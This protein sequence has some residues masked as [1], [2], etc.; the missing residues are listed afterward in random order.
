M[1]LTKHTSPLTGTSKIRL[2]K[3]FASKQLIHKYKEAY[4]INIERFFTGCNEIQ[5]V[6]CI[7][8]GY[9]FFVPNTLAGDSLFYEKL[10]T[11]DW[12]YMPWKWEHQQT[13]EFILPEMKVLEIGSAKGDF[14]KKIENDIGAKCV[15]LELNNSA[16]EYTKSI[17]LEVYLETIQTFSIKNSEVFDI[18]CSFQ[19]LEHVSEIYSFIESMIKC[20]KKGGKLIIGV[21]NNDSFLGLSENLLNM[22][23]HH[24]GLWNKKSLIALE[25][26][27]PLKVVDCYFEPLQHYHLDYYNKVINDYKIAKMDENILKYGFIGR[28]KNQ[29]LKKSF[30]KLLKKKHPQLE[31]YTILVE[32]EKL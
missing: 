26:I 12:Y 7:E 22:P 2:V 27:F 13:A 4:N 29:I 19:V 17:G 1:D 23:P 10:E 9:K 28:I 8:T 14:I 5:L 32:F 24:M 25:K 11:F 6:E 21:P 31:N 20:L 16:F 18:V 15:G 30:L 3:T